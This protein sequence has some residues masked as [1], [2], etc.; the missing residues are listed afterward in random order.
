VKIRRLHI[1]NFR[2]LRDV[3]IPL[4]DVTVLIGENNAGK[5]ALLDA[6]RLALRGPRG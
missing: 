5:S 6:L 4:D 2:C 3:E 1:R